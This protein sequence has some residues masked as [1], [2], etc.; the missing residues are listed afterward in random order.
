M[1]FAA[2]VIVDRRQLPVHRI[3]R[4][5]RKPRIPGRAVSFQHLGPVIAD[6]GDDAQILARH[7]GVFQRDRDGFLVAGLGRVEGVRAI[8]RIVL[9]A[10]MAVAAVMQRAAQRVGGAQIDPGL[11]ARPPGPVVV[12]DVEGAALCLAALGGIV[13]CRQQVV[14]AVVIGA[15]LP[16]AATEFGVRIKGQAVDVPFRPCP[17]PLRRAGPFRSRPSAHRQ[18]DVVGRALGL[19]TGADMRQT[20]GIHPQPL[21]QYFEIQTTASVGRIFVSLDQVRE[22]FLQCAHFAQSEQ[23]GKPQVAI[24][25]N[26]ARREI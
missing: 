10:D 3:G 25:C 15:G 17:V 8:G 9:Q 4:A 12:V 1:I 6:P 22:S 18:I 14:E 20:R 11:G 2:A 16:I 13:P 26:P 19:K 5:G 24:V 7:P 23:R 21:R